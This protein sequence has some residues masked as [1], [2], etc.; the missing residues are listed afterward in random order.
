MI[1]P[2]DHL[3]MSDGSIV[4][5]VKYPNIAE[6]MNDKPGKE[7][8]PWYTQIVLDG[9]RLEYTEKAKQFISPRFTSWESFT[10][11][12]MMPLQAFALMVERAVQNTYTLDYPL[13]GVELDMPRFS[14][15]ISD[16]QPD[17]VLEFMIGIPQLDIAY[18]RTIAIDE[19]HGL[20]CTV[21]SHIFELMKRMAQEFTEHLVMKAFTDAANA[22][23]Q[24]QQAKTDKFH[25][26]L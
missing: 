22:F 5:P 4:P 16:N 19:F 6:G 26:K 3:R 8:I 7:L 18:A 12:M 21:E 10:T 14:V 25:N 2:Y 1:N 23:K 11:S 17:R 13:G 20:H 15:R 9:I 24:L